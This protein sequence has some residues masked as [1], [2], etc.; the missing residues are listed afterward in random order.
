MRRL[1]YRRYDL[2]LLVIL[3]A[4][5]EE[6]SITRASETLNLTQPAVSH[7][8]AR[9]RDVFKDPLF[10]RRGPTMVP[11]PLA[12]QMA[13]R[14][15]G[16]LDS[17]ASL[18]EEAEFDPARERRVFRLALRDVF[19]SAVLPPLMAQIERE[20]SP[21]E[22]HSV[23]TDRDDLEAE[24]KRGAIDLAVD[25]PMSVGEEIMRQHVQQDPLVVVA[26]PGHPAVEDGRM[27]LPAYLGAEHIL[28][29]TRRKGPGLADYELNRQGMH[30]RIKLRCQH[31][32]AAWRVVSETDLLLTMPGHYAQV[33]SL[34]IPNQ[35]LAFPLAIAPLDAVMYWHASLG[36]DPATRWLRQRMVEVLSGLDPCAFSPAARPGPAD[37]GAGSFP[38]AISAA[39]RGR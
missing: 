36:E 31:Y 8:L 4:I 18:T 39:S 29:S 6:G 21:V 20:G 27:A 5:L 15:R 10:V 3:N 12:R 30:R 9:L 38:P 26:R 16:A 22:I 23:R 7:A 14:I 37:P 35:R 1:H 19:E 28:V 17:L 32:F 34:A 33:L 24:L 25:V 13:E 2:N 11:T